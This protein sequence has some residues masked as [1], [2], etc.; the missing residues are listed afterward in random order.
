MTLRRAAI[1]VAASHALVAVVGAIVIAPGTRAGDGAAKAMEHVVRNETAW[2]LAWLLPAFAALAMLWMWSE[3]RDALGAPLRVAFAA[4]VVGA[5]VEGAACAYAAAALPVYAADSPDR[6]MVD[7]LAGL[8][9]VRLGTATFGGLGFAAAQ[10]LFTR[11]LHRAEIG[12]E[13]V[14]PGYACAAAGVL[15]MA[16]GL[17]DSENALPAANGLLFL[18]LIVFALALALRAPQVVAAR[19]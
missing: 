6:E 18:T 4:A 3:V 2:Q 19:S 9:V 14:W 12:G 7:F 16:A 10:L 15:F 5:A 8:R 11:A 1:A 17:S 13:V